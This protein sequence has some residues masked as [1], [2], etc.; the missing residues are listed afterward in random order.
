M[1]G[2]A[3]HATSP[4]NEDYADHGVAGARRRGREFHAVRHEPDAAGHPP[5]ATSARNS[6]R[7]RFF[8][9]LRTRWPTP[10]RRAESPASN[11][12]EDLRAYVQQAFD[13]SAPLSSSIDAEVG[14]SPLI[15]E[16]SISDVNG[17]VLVSSD[18]S[19]PGNADR[20]PGRT[21]RNWFPS[22]FTQPAQGLRSYGPPR[23][24]EVTY[25]FQLGPPGT[26]SRSE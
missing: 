14:Y 5:G 18:K 25:P 4:E 13:E 11:S 21:S 12:P 20:P 16:V 24:Y 17:T 2:G 8:S 15:Y 6:F 26:R 7:G 9:R 10:P 19:L 23:T 22:G 1:R 3:T